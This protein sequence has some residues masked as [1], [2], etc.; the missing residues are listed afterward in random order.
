MKKALI[1]LSSCALLLAFCAVGVLYLYEN[2]KNLET[3]KESIILAAKAALDRDVQYARAAFSLK[4][5]PVFTFTDVVV[6]ERNGLSP[7][8]TIERLTLKVAIMPL[9]WKS[10]VFK[11]V[12]L[13]HPRITIQRDAAGAWN[14]GDLLEVKSDEAVKVRRVTVSGGTVAFSD[15]SVR[16]GGLNIVLKALDFSLRGLERGGKT[17]LALKADVIQ[18]ATTGRIESDGDVTLPSTGISWLEAIPDLRLRA[19]Q[20][21]VGTYWPYVAPL[22]PFTVAKA[23]LDI[24]AVV[25]GR[26][27]DGASSGMVV[28]RGP[29]LHFPTVFPSVLSPGRVQLEYDVKRA[30]G[31]VSLKKL[32]LSADDVQ[33]V[34]SAS[35]RDLGTKDPFMDVRLRTNKAA[36]E[37]FSPY[38]PLGILPEKVAAYIREHIQGGIFHVAEGSLSGRLSQVRNMNQGDNANVLNARIGVEKG[39]LSYGAPVPLFRDIRGELSFRGP[40]F[41]LKGMSGTFGESPLVLEGAIRNYCLDLPSTYPFSMTMKATSREIGWILGAEAMKTARIKGRSVLKLNGEGPLADYKLSGDWD[42]TPLDYR[43]GRFA[44]PEGRANRLKMAADIRAG[45]MMVHMFKYDLLPISLSGTARWRFQKGPYTSVDVRSNAF[46]LKDLSHLLP[47]METY[48]AVGPVRVQLKG[49]SRPQA[50][51]EL[52]WKGE[53]V[54]GGAAIKP[55]ADMKIFED[56]RGVVRLSDETASTSD[57][58]FTLGGASCQVQGRV[59]NFE[60]PTADLNFMS[61]V[62]N[63]ADLGFVNSRGPVRL[64]TIKGRIVV[65]ED[66]IQVSSL[67]ARL[68]QSILTASLSWPRHAAN[69]VVTFQID[70]PVLEQEDLLWIAGLGKAASADGQGV[71]TYRGS[72]NAGKGKLGKLDYTN[73]RAHVSYREPKL[74]INQ[75]AFIAMGGN[76]SG[77]G[78]IDLTNRNDPFYDLDFRVAGVPAPSLLGMTDISADKMSGVVSSKGYIKASGRNKEDLKRTLQGRIEVQVDKGVLREFPVLA[79]I[80]SILN[81]SQLLKFRLPDMAEGG[82]PF[83]KITATVSIH[84]G[85]IET[86]NAFL[87]SEAMNM[88]AVGKADML[89]ETLDMMVGLQ[90]LQSVDKVV[91]RIPVLGWILTDTDKRFITVNFEAKGAWKDPAVR[92]IPVRE[93][94]KEILNIIKRVF[95]L[96]VKLFTDTGDVL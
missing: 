14:I 31:I 24:D 19:R 64:Q 26:W 94:A 56:I 27:S 51:K 41:L 77:T 34:G 93:M 52:K 67:S 7:F 82:M 9:F 25:K 32:N 36:F 68:N 48:Q 73:L 50:W 55:M 29:E 80:F 87:K 11:D 96:P 47:G 91:S 3:R 40:D 59:M 74:V 20:L 33:V 53:I 30:P 4:A 63:P 58:T 89:K 13:E 92:A 57:L 54:F 8:A 85:L 22:V 1:V 69:P 83:N 43:F 39:I 65:N 45:E 86:D 38:L 44:K 79:K 95:Q 23:T 71:R 78:M 81:V 66:E 5:G 15:Q 76:F 35:V 6:K 2:L 60:N 42:L 18:G 12:Q 70:A 10:L 61:D 28:L 17:H 72:L 62:L 84:D 37:K 21:D 16:P 75:L 90:P 46:D 88:I 49:E